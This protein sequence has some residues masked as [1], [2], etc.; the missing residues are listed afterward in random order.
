MLERELLSDLQI[1]QMKE[2]KKRLREREGELHIVSDLALRPATEEDIPQMEHILRQWYLEI[3]QPA[4]PKVSM[5]RYCDRLFR[6]MKGGIETGAAKYFLYE[7]PCYNTKTG[8]ITDELL[9]FVGFSEIP[10]NLLDEL[11]REEASESQ[12]PQKNLLLRRI[13]SEIEKGTLGY[14][15]NLY[16]NAQVVGGREIGAHLFNRVQTEAYSVGYTG[17]LYVTSAPWW[18]ARRNIYKPPQFQELTTFEIVPGLKANLCYDDLRVL[19]RSQFA[20]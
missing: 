19:A 6:D 16:R 7:A 18:H 17:L 10:V 5:E 12:D 3:A 13:S 20:D 11:T 4:F 2:E 15:R 8:K 14:A 1:E 9:S